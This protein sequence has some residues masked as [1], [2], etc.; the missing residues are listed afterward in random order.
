VELALARR[1]LS[2][3]S[4]S[5]NAWQPWPGPVQVLVGASAADI[6]QTAAFR[7]DAP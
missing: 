3:F 1:H 5:A 7:Y 4:K 2:F 6:R